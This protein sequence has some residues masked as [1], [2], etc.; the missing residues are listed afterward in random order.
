MAEKQ[1]EFEIADL[2]FNSKFALK[3]ASK[4]DLKFV[5]SNS[6]R[7]LRLPPSSRRVFRVRGDEKSTTRY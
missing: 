5:I 1:T 4:F 7:V 2:K 6:P 3:F